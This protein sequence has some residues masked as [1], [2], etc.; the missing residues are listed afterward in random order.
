MNFSLYNYIY[1]SIHIHC[2]L[3][4]CVFCLTNIEM[5]NNKYDIIEITYRIK[6]L[7]KPNI[8]FDKLMLIVELLTYLNELR[9]WLLDLSKYVLSQG[10]NDKDKHELRRIIKYNEREELNKKFRVFVKMLK[11]LVS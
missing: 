5:Q 7:I 8:Q 4:L 9:L 11:R 10:I 1:I 2:F 3:I 6:L